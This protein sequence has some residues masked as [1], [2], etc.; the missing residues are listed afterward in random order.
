MRRELRIRSIRM[1]AIRRRRE[2]FAS[3]PLRSSDKSRLR[4]AQRRGCGENCALEV[5]VCKPS[6]VDVERLPGDEAGLVAEKERDGVGDIDGLGQAAQR[7]AGV[8][9]RFADIA[10]RDVA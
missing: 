7:N 1:Q 4:S 6:A 10:G 5:S 3:A 2:R 9:L 8:E